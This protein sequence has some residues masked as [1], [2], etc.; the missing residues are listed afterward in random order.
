MTPF[1]GELTHGRSVFS[2]IGRLIAR[3]PSS[4]YRLKFTA[5]VRIARLSCGLGDAIYC[6]SLRESGQKYTGLPQ[7]FRALVARRG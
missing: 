3:N 7:T 4:P 1:G 2:V 6:N 5:F